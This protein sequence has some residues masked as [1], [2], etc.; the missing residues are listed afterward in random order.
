MT[1]KAK[2]GLIFRLTFSCVNLLHGLLQWL[3][4][5]FKFRAISVV[6]LHV[7]VRHFKRSS[8]A[9]N[10]GT[11]HRLH[12]LHWL[13]IWPRGDSNGV[14]WRQHIKDIC[15]TVS[16]VSIKRFGKIFACD[17]QPLVIIQWA[18]VARRV[19]TLNAGRN[20]SFINVTH[21]MRVIGKKQDSAN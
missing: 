2:Q 19:Q 20:L 6:C 21:V 18:A 8:V 16:T 10:C 1:R 13:Q 15:R 4:P 11:K 3:K 14:I 7:W 9:S 5:G 17:C 12:C